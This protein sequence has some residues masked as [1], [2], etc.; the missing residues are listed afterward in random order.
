MTPTSMDPAQN[1]MMML[2]PIVFTFLFLNFASGLVLYW[3]MNN[4]FSIAQQFYANR[5]LAK[6]A[7]QTS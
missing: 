7:A 5:K 2:M 3:L 4:I 6:E 1:K